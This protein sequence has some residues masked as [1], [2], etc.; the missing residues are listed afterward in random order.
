MAGS[1]LRSAGKGAMEPPNCL[2]ANS[3]RTL[4]ARAH[5][6]GIEALQ[7]EAR[8]MHAVQAKML[9]SQRRAD[10]AAFKV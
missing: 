2:I 7:Q 1:G 5:S 8:G 9:R 10:N 6:S 3:R 4:K